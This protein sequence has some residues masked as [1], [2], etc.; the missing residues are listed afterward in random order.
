MCLYL[1]SVLVMFHF[2]YNLI[3]L[4]KGIDA[5]LMP[6][7]GPTAR[8]FIPCTSVGRANKHWVGGK[9]EWVVFVRDGARWYQFNVY[10]KEEIEVPSVHNVGIHPDD[11]FRYHCNMMRLELLKIQIVKKPYNAG[12]GVWNYYIIA[13]F[14][15]MIAIM[16]GGIDLQWRI[17]KNGCLASSQTYVDAIHDLHER[18]YAVTGPRGDVYVWDPLEWG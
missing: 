5:S 16:R 8:A 10:S 12:L 2:A 15:K 17:L 4:Y 11:P 18:I 9:D 6:L 13:V 1:F 3:Q 7:Y 14:D